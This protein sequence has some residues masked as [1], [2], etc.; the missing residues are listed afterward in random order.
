MVAAAAGI[1]CRAWPPQAPVRHARDLTKTPELGGRVADGDGGDSGR[2]GVG[3]VGSMGVPNGMTQ[4]VNRFKDNIPIMVAVASVGHEML[5]REATQEA[6]HADVMT[7]PI[8]K[9]YWAAQSAE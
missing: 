1:V 5:G 4:M 6:E 8:T 7:Q 2:G 3:V 9:W